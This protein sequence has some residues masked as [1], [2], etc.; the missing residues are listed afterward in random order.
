MTSKLYFTCWGPEIADKAVDQLDA[1]VVRDER[2]A[3]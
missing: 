3:R 1:K 2:C